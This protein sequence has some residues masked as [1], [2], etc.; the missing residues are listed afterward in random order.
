MRIMTHN[1]LHLK[2]LGLFSWWPWQLCINHGIMGRRFPDNYSFDHVWTSNI[3]FPTTPIRLIQF[4]YL[5]NS[6]SGNLLPI[7]S[8]LG[9]LVQ[10]SPHLAPVR[11]EE[12][13]PWYV[14]IWSIVPEQLLAIARITDVHLVEPLVARCLE[15]VDISILGKIVLQCLFQGSLAERVNQGENVWQC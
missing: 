14:R 5:S 13:E 2:G 12:V 4:L 7:I 11:H 9:P 6:P 8:C 3:V 1:K 15:L 10:V